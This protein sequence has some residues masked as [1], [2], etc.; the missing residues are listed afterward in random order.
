MHK[1]SDMSLNTA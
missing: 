1:I